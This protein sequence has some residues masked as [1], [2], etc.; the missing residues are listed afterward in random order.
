MKAFRGTAILS[1]CVVALALYTAWEYKKAGDSS[2]DAP[3]EKH[4]F[5]FNSDQVEQ[6]QIIRGTETILIVLEGDSWKMK[7]PFV[8]DAETSVMD[9]FI[10]SVRMQKG[11]TFR[12][13]DEKKATKWADFG[14]EPPGSV[15]EITSNKKT[16]TLAVSSKNAF[17]GSYYIRQGDELMLGDHGLAQIIGRDA[18]AFRSRRLWREGEAIVESVQAAIDLDKIKDKITVKRNGENYQIE[19]MPAFPVDEVRLSQWVRNILALTPNEIASDT[20]SEEEKRQFLLVKPSLE[21][22]VQFKKADGGKGDWS[23]TIGQDKADDVYLYTNQRPTVYKSN[24]KSLAKIRV[25]RQYFRDSKHAFKIPVERAHEVQISKGE[26]KHGF[27]KEGSTWKLKEGGKDWELNADKL[28]ALFQALSSLEAD[29][30]PPGKEAKGFKGDQQLLVL[31]DKGKIIF[32]LKWGDE[33]KAKQAYNKGM[34]LRFVQTNLE[35]DPMGVN[36]SKIA[37]LIDTSLVK[38]KS[39]GKKAESK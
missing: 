18:S 16:E 34:T 33:F 25:D 10:Y 30:F 8:D 2:G 9:A 37:G 1:L 39:D 5:L 31:D 17:D 36:A 15:V 19:P 26:F 35:K 6:V 13:E 29:E 3:E 24:S 20:L 32:D 21:A 11:K 4:L 28:A 7:K 22:H 38:K 23:L 12:G 14:L 27:I